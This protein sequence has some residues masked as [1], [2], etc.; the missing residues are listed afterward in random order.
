MDGWLFDVSHSVFRAEPGPESD[1]AWERVSKLGPMVMSGEEVRKIG[2]NP[3]DV[4]K[5][6]LEWGTS[7][8]LSLQKSAGKFS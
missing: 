3:D 6:S 4:V 2:K 5:A 7:P 8:S 1:A